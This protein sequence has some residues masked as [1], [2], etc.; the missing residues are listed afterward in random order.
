M[1]CNCDS[2]LLGLSERCAQIEY[3]VPKCSEGESECVHRAEDVASIPD[4]GDVIFA[5]GHQHN[6]GM[7]AT[8]LKEVFWSFC[9]H[10]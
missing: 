10:M 4:G 5:V 3:T 7:G 9:P 8:L 6:G 2:T 1:D